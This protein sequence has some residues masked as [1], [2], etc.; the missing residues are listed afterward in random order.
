MTSDQCSLTCPEPHQRTPQ[1]LNL[2]YSLR[3]PTPL[4]PCSKI[5]RQVPFPPPL[6]LRL[7]KPTPPLS[8]LDLHPSRCLCPT[9][10]CPCTRQYLPLSLAPSVLLVVSL[11]QLPPLLLVLQLLVLVR[12]TC[13]LWAPSR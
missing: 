11:M 10:E 6:L 5:K 13:S 9:L 7:P 1:L 8:A 3:I 12:D 4:L 2:L